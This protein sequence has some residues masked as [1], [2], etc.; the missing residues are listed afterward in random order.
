VDDFGA[1]SASV[2]LLRRLPVTG[3]K[4][5]RAVVATIDGSAEGDALA[6]ALVRLTHTMELPVTADGVTTAGQLEVLRA[7]RCAFAQGPLLS[8][9]LPA[10]GLPAFLGAGAPAV[11]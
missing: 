11:T 6:R 3:L 10:A 1:G 7:M 8:E 2:A 5:G 4:L 9:A